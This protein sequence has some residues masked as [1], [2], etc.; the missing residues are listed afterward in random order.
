MRLQIPAALLLPLVASGAALAGSPVRI[1]GVHFDGLLAGAPEPDSAVRLINTDPKRPANVAGF[2]LS[3]A[4]AVKRK[5]GTAVEGAPVDEGTSESGAGGALRARAQAALKLPEGAVIPPGGEIWLAASADAFLQVF[6]ALPAYEATDT[7]PDVDDLQ[8][9]AFLLMPAEHGAVALLDDAGAV[10]DFVPYEVSKEG[11]FDDSA[12]AGLPWKGPAVRLKKTSFYG[13][14]GQV[15]ARDRD[16]QGRALLDTDTAA[17]WDSGFS[18]KLLGEDET[19]RIEIA[20]QSRFVVRPLRVRAKVKAT[21]A[22]DNNYA[23]LVSAIQSATK[24]LRVRIYEMT[25]PKIV[26]ELIKA[27][28]RGVDVTVFLEGSPV[29]GIAD[30][31]RW[32]VDRAFKAGVGVYFLATP[33]GSKLKPRYRFDHSKYVLVDE[34]LAIVGTENFGRTGV[35]VFT[36]FGNRGW[37][38]H[39]EEPHFVK[40]L[41]EVWDADFRRG[42]SADV[43]AIDAAPDDAYGLPYRKADFTPDEELHRGQ[44]PDPVKP[45]VVDDTMNLELVLSPDTSLNERSAI[46]GM[47]GRAKKT[48]YVEQNS[49]RRRWGKKADSSDPDS[50]ERDDADNAPNLPL[51]AVVKAARRGV[52]V[53]VLLDSTWYNVQGDEDRDNDDTVAWLNELARTEGLDIAAKVI[54][55]ETT[56]LEKIHAKGVI[57]DDKE[58]FVGSINWTEN[59]FKGNREVGVVVG[60]PKVAGYYAKLFR[61]DWAQSRIY[62]ADVVTKATIHA[63][64]DGRS[65]VLRRVGRGDRVFAV[66]ELGAAGIGGKR[67]GPTWVEVQL[68]LGETGFIQPNALGL[69]ECSPGEAL[70][71]VGKEAVII[72]RVAATNV[73]DRRVQ[74]R[75]ADEARPPFTAVIFKKNEAS[76]VAKG[77]AP[78][79]AFQGREVRVQGKVTTYRGPEIIVAEPDQIAIVR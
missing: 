77:L 1:S 40:Q 4:F 31:E 24:E 22:P 20:G 48:L 43:I 25:N 35:P 42:V 27:K 28:R 52:Q 54:N 7:R 10:I 72:G 49:I 76:F 57:I 14:K 33:K 8:G 58:V 78:A 11:Y 2:A 19:H 66:G 26:E 63:A 74:L 79:S 59:S 39:V 29:G 60:H 62:A 41:R 71:V 9:G 17:D 69:P 21:S 30:Q 65:K 64:R 3:E 23:E 6:G 16:E 50:E 70:H 32:L 38:V 34:R 75:F 18:R 51:Q 37:M 13:W 68:A 46:I 61:R 36:S 53:R 44:Y 55:L 67:D 73:S 5:K 47:M 56:H 45:L 15:L 12:L